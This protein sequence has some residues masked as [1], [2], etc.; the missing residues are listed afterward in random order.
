MRS[1]VFFAFVLSLIASCLSLHAQTVSPEAARAKAMDFFST[2][3]KNLP[4]RKGA[5]RKAPAVSNVELAYTSEKGGKTCFYVYNNGTDGGFVIV[6][7]DEVAQEI[8]AYVPQGHFD[9]DKAPD[10]LKWWLGQYEQE[11]DSA[12]FINSHSTLS[13]KKEIR[14]ASSTNTRRNIDD[15][16]TTKWDQGWPYNAAIPLPSPES[17]ERS[18][19]GCVP[20]AIAQIMN[21]WKW[22]AAGRGEYEYEY[23][24]KIYS[25]D[26]GSTTYDWTN[27]ADD[28]SYGNPN[29]TQIDAVSTLMYHVGVAFHSYYFPES[30]E[31]TATDQGKTDYYSLNLISDLVQYF[32]YDKGM[33]YLYREDF[34][35]EQWESIL[36]NELASGRPVYYSGVHGD[37]GVGHAFVC[38]G[39]SASLNM[40]SINWGWSG[41]GDGYFA[42]S[43]TKTLLGFTGGLGMLIGMRPAGYVSNTGE[44]IFGDKFKYEGIWYKVIDERNREVE[45]THPD[46][47][48]NPDNS[49]CSGDVIIPSTV[50]YNGIT[51]TVSRIGTNAFWAKDP[52]D[53]K[54]GETVLAK[55][56]TLPST[57]TSLAYSAFRSCDMDSIVLPNDIYSIPEECFHGG[58]KTI[59]LPSNLKRI[60]RNAFTGC[61]FEE[62]TIP[63]GCEI[64]T[65]YAFSSCGRLSKVNLPSTI[66]TIGS[67]CF[68]GTSLIN[69]LLPCAEFLPLQYY[70]VNG[71]EYKRG[72]SPFPTCVSNGI[73]YVPNELVETYRT[74]K[75]EF[76]RKWGTVESIDNYNPNIGKN[77]IDDSF[78][79]QIINDSCVSLTGHQL[80]SGS[81][82]GDIVVPST[83]TY[84]G[85]NYSV[86]SIGNGALGWIP[87]IDRIILPEGIIEV[88]QNAFNGSGCTSILLPNSL[89]KIGEGAFSHCQELESIEIPAGVRIVNGFWNCESL[90]QVI[91]HDGAE[92]LGINL[93]SG[94]PKLTE[95]FFPAS[96]WYLP[97]GELTECESLSKIISLPVHYTFFD[98][99]NPICFDYNLIGDLV[100]RWNTGFGS[101]IETVDLVIPSSLMED[102]HS[103]YNTEWPWNEMP[104]KHAYVP[105]ESFEIPNSLSLQK[106]EQYTIPTQFFPENASYQ[107]LKWSSSD[108]SV[109]RV[110]CD[111]TVYALRE[112]EAVITALAIDGSG[113]KHSCTINVSA[114]IVPTNVK[115]DDCLAYLSEY[116]FMEQMSREV[117]S[118]EL[119]ISSSEGD[120]VVAFDLSRWTRA[121]TITFTM[122][123]QTHEIYTPSLYEEHL[124]R[125]VLL[126]FMNVSFEDTLKITY[127]ERYHS[128]GGTGCIV[129]NLR[130]MDASSF[131]WIIPIESIQLEDMTLTKGS[132]KPIRL[133]AFPTNAAT[134]GQIFYSSGNPWV[135]KISEKGIITA[136]GIGE[137]Q[138]LA[139]TSDGIAVGCKVTVKER[140][141]GTLVDIIDGLPSGRTTLKD[142][143]DAVDSI[144]E[145]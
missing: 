17:T 129:S 48:T 109:A 124:N 84:N 36:Y 62:I 103:E 29:Q 81:G 105:M 33:D 117:Q 106:Y 22:P 25:A 30:E 97:G 86:Y 113:I 37:T 46:W 66:Q 70:T 75:D 92:C 107:S 73:L 61:G 32:D 142:V 125:A 96:F 55:S 7:G 111:G 71:I 99:F 141:L 65:E 91:L 85:Q 11:I 21:Y 88:G 98:I 78:K 45:V 72:A 102:R 115:P 34:P 67:R 24:D 126:R 28:Y 135:A 63:E 12:I 44:P 77:F 145:R 2:G 47:E 53:G 87:F 93:L 74:T 132:S 4:A 122:A 9:Y 26:F 20:T 104:N 18:T 133:Q 123:G 27:M 79:F 50:E 69:M 82:L 76:W 112:G 144:L 108:E 31:G 8:L 5:M 51:Y 118:L 23:D 119:P 14:Q 143:D 114:E 49:Y 100:G 138:I 83:A 134:E 116:Y 90:K 15:M 42:I 35:E 38:H 3:A 59:I 140:T 128:V 13:R 16:I 130:V 121:N 54:G 41:E 94:C 139:W 10:N 68:E 136:T 39:Y 127:K 137:T 19:T 43:G 110:S 56:V 120:V 64:I 40:F 52:W 89:K 1:K 6:G 60:G 95:V 58:G 131:D 80:G 101:N 57:I